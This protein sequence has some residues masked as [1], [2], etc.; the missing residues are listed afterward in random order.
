MA[1]PAPA[2][3]AS[4]RGDPGRVGDRPARHA[5]AVGAGPHL[6]LGAREDTAGLID[7]LGDARVGGVRVWAHGG[8][9]GLETGY[10]PDLGVAFAL[11]L[12][13]RAPGLPGLRA[14]GDAVIGSLLDGRVHSSWSRRSRPT[15]Q[16]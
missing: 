10:V 9:W 14:L 16:R 3:R 6:S 1:E 5:T 13:H 11:S 7:P 12:T 4:G 8:F 15:S 2:N